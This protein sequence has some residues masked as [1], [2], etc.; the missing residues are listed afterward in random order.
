MKY[1]EESQRIL[2]TLFPEIMDQDWP[3][4]EEMLLKESGMTYED[5][6]NNIEI[7]VN[8]GYSV[9]FQMKLVADV[10]KANLL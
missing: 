8:N 1:K 3:E 4:F 10:V 7:G 6:S 5:L 9:E 2:R